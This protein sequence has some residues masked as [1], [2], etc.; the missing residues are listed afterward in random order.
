LSRVIHIDSAGKE[1]TRL[2]KTVVLALR[3]LMLQKQ[4]NELSCDLV[5]YVCLALDE[6]NKSIDSSVEAWEKR[7][8]WLK[9][10]RFRLEWE[11]TG[12]VSSELRKSLLAQDW[13]T[14]ALLSAKIAQKLMKIDVPARHRLGTPWIGAWALVKK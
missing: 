10:D 13:A 12:T 6:I 4:A 9:A 1:R 5:A 14:I 11:W 2:L 3:E 7:G 8:Y